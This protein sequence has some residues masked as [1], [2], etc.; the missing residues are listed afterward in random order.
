M[1]P[2]ASE[3]LTIPAGPHQ[4][5]RMI[6][7]RTAPGVYHRRSAYFVTDR[8][9]LV[10]PRI[11][12][13]ARHR[14]NAFPSNTATHHRPTTIFN[15]HYAVWIS[16]HRVLDPDDACQ[17][18]HSGIILIPASRKAVAARVHLIGVL[19]RA[20]PDTEP[21]SPRRRNGCTGHAQKI[22]AAAVPFIPAYGLR[23]AR[24]GGQ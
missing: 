4:P 6:G 21:T 1:C 2:C 14:S 9:V 7:P 10:G 13:R 18:R 24:A 11:P 8:R 19:A 17:D 20:R 3:K 12:A 22:A 16:M 23:R 15:T 5:R